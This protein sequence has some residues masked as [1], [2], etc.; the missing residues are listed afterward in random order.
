MTVDHDEKCPHAEKV[1]QTWGAV[2]LNGHPK[3]SLMVRM[4]NVENT[5][6]NMDEKVDDLKKSFDQMGNKILLWLSIAVA[7]I[8]LLQFLG[9]SIRKAIGLNNESSK[10][11][12]VAEYEAQE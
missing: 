11:S 2:F 5:Q 12:I 8:A 1:N 6:A 9:P 7:L 10:V 4:S 3:G